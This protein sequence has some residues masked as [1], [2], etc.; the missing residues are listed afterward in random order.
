MMLKKTVGTVGTLAQGAVSTAVSVAKHPIET[1]AL[2]A[3]L[4]KGA[5]GA[6]IGLLRSTIS[7]QTPTPTS[8]TDLDATPADPLDDETVVPEPQARLRSVPERDLPGPDVVAAA[9]PTADE[10]PEPVVIEAEPALPT[11]GDLGEVFHTEPKA[12]SRDSEHGGQAG[13]RE[14]AEGYVEEIPDSFAD[15]P[16]W[17]SETP[18]DEPLESVFD[19]SAAKTV[20]SEAEV[21]QKAADQHVE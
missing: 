11:G 9:V 16:V 2:A 14:E 6:G 12:A 3:G 10:L 1:S 4:V 8:G 21:L 17:T 18:L 19:E 7:G 5:A 15:T 20:R 13:D